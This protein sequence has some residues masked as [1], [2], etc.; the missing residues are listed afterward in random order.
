MLLSNSEDIEIKPGQAAAKDDQERAIKIR[1]VQIILNL[2][3]LVEML[4]KQPGEPIR[5][6]CR[7]GKE[8]SD[9]METRAG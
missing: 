9:K 6:I 1:H 8:S 5:L 3:H 7:P 2:F 4:E